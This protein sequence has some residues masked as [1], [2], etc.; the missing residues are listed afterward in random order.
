MPIDKQKAMDELGLPEEAFNELLQLFMEQTTIAI[1]DLS[2]AV[3]AKNYEKTARTAHLIK[4][5]ALDLRIDE[6][7]LLAKEIEF[8]AK[9]NKD[10]NVLAAKTGELKKLFEELN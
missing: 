8:G 1:R 9:E 5:S 6:I 7:H 3:G 4:G 10:M 2:D